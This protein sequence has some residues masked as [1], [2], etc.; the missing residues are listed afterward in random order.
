MPEFPQQPIKFP[1]LEEWKKSDGRPGH[2]IENRQANGCYLSSERIKS[3]MAH[4]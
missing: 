1:G 4:R 3:P 2:A